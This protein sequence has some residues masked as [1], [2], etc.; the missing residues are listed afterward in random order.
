ME[1]C[2]HCHYCGVP[3]PLQ[4]RR[5]VRVVLHTLSVVPPPG[6][7]F[8]LG[9]GESIDVVVLTD[10]LH[11]T[12]VLW[13]VY[14]SG[15]SGR[16]AETRP[17]HYTP[18]HP[19]Y[20]F[21]RGRGRSYEWEPTLCRSDTLVLTPTTRGSNVPP[22]GT[23]PT[24]VPSPH[25]PRSRGSVLDVQVDPHSPLSLRAGPLGSRDFDHRAPGTGG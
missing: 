14:V 1:R 7:G 16:D 10:S 5:Q 19:D 11:L 8:R 17:T 9:V 25:P 22:A 4:R 23:D 15:H 13:S 20:T 6:E 2:P 3:L 21:R 12:P 18:T 24:L